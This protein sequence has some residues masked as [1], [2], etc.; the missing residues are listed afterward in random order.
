M[1]SRITEGLELLESIWF[2][3]ACRVVEAA[4]R[5]YKLNAEQAAALRE[6]YLKPNQFRVLLEPPT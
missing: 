2:S 6:V 3:L 4:I 1:D 5:V